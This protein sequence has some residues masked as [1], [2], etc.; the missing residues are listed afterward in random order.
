MT[1]A[2]SWSRASRTGSSH[3]KHGERRQ[4]AVLCGGV[5]GKSDIFFSAISDGAGSAV[6]GGHGAALTVRLFASRFR[7]YAQ[8]AHS[9]PDNDTLCEW[10]DDLRDLIA[11]CA[12][13][14]KRLISDFACTLVFAASN[15]SESCFFKI[16]DGASSYRSRLDNQWKVPIWPTHGEFA[17]TTFFVTDARQPF[18][19]YALIDEEIDAIISF[20]DGL[21]LLALDMKN[22][23]AFE[24]FFR[25][26]IKPFEDSNSSGFQNNLADALAN[27]L[28][29][30]RVCSRTDDDKTISIALR[31]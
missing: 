5:S 20:T 2:W 13:R 15:G 27:F 29:S 1:L 22:T 17:S 31:K 21:E 14:R 7:E 26:M 8:F 28:E 19:E 4:D 3:I 9:M 12:E 23:Q 11:I 10:L 18:S 30:E 6:C 25:G 16:G 24:P